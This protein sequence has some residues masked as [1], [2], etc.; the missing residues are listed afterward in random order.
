MS[1]LWHEMAEEVLKAPERSRTPVATELTP[2]DH[3]EWT[4]FTKVLSEIGKREQM[5]PTVEPPAQN[6]LQ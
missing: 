4:D 1:K 6:N 5:E 3:P 2:H